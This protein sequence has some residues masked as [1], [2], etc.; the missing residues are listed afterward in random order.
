MINTLSG[1]RYDGSN[2]IAL[3][4]GACGLLGRQ[5][6][7]ALYDAGFQVVATD[8][9]DQS[10]VESFPSDIIYR[11][12]DVTDSASIRTVDDEFDV[13]VLV[14]NAAIDAKVGTDGLEE[15]KTL[16]G[17][18]KEAISLEV[19]VGLIGATLCSGIFGQSM[20]NRGYGNIINI[21]SDLSVISPKHSLYNESGTNFNDR[22]VKPVTYSIIKH[23]LI[24][25]TKY[26]ATYWDGV[27]RCNALSPG[28]VYNGQNDHF[29]SS[30]S[31]E[32]PLGRMAYL[33][34]YRGTLQFLATD[35][36]AYMNGHNLIVYGGRS[37]W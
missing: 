23:G 14:N 12:L 2:K 36:S 8:L 17:I 10:T 30:I 6:V 19:E 34:E 16:Q 5:H 9:N 28:G 31:Q 25:L 29:V 3:V 15:N 22:K 21:A 27:V 13:D 20:Y 37:I 24:G 18:S 7:S 32:I 1:T 26:L 33:N 35:A 11:R 4:T